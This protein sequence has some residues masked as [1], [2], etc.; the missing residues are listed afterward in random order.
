MSLTRAI[1]EAR[2]RG[3]PANDLSQ[4]AAEQRLE[5]LI[6]VRG[7]A[8]VSDQY[9]ALDRV[10]DLTMETHFARLYQLA[11]DDEERDAA[12]K[13][14]MDFER[15]DRKHDANH[16]THRGEVKGVEAF[17]RERNPLFINGSWTPPA[18]G[19]PA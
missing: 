1:D 12:V 19:R 8:D 5:E 6:K 17:M 11:D 14:F 18:S 13:A 10:E 4:E 7:L 3:R 16:N 2:R 9:E 15:F